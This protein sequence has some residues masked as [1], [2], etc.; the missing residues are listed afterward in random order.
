MVVVVVVV[1]VVIV[2]IVRGNSNRC[3]ISR[4]PLLLESHLTTAGPLTD[5]SSLMWTGSRE[6]ND[7][8]RL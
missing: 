5:S 8:A 2:V 3:N 1:V 6:G 7:H 4:D